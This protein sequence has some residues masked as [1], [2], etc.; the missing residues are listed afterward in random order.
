MAERRRLEVSDLIAAGQL[1]VGDG[2][3]AK[4]EELSNVGIPFARA[5]NI[6][7]GFQFEDADH[8][9][10]DDLHRVGNKVS[11]P[12]D[13][14]FTSKGTVGRFAF[15]QPK[16]QRFVY[17]PQLCFW[18]VI[19][20]SLIDPRFL[21]YWMHSREFFL[22]FK[23]VA[24]QTDMAEYV[25]LTDQRR[26]HITLPD[27]RDQGNIATVLG[28]LD[29]K[30]NLNRQVNATL[31]TMAQA[32]FNDWFVDFGPLRA[33]MG[34]LPLSGPA[35]LVQNLFPATFEGNK[36][37]G[38]SFT[39]LEK[40][41]TKI[42]SGATPRG[43]KGVYVD[44]GTNFIR[45]QNVYDHRFEWDGLAR[46]TDEDAHKLRSV[47]VEPQDILLNITGDSIL[48][49]CVVDP[50]V[51]PARVNQH[52]AI[53]RAAEE[54]PNRFLHFY[55]SRPST[56]AHLIGN[57]AGGSRA[58]VTKGHLENLPVLLPPQPILNAFDT[59]TKPWFS[60]I[61]SNNSEIR[62][63]SALRNLILP[64]LMSGAI[65]LKAAENKPEN[66]L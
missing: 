26:M 23:G 48:R 35:K 39:T 18:R 20:K 19:D 42:G 11:Q 64:K 9:P 55:L 21:F 50:D 25:S 36:P 46:I 41:T 14:V 34:N 63:L 62:D 5:G 29:D 8:F 15:V 49:T 17:S 43:G 16:T 57:D 28:A 61:S 2:Y 1:V 38:W 53:I 33:K 66:V 51:L 52:V 56:K 32:V 44:K 6:N 59:L 7:N 27:I 12:G 58:A 37:H 10:E 4:N 45:S 65:R 3:R 13:V 40:L 31:G 54:I 30:I 47:T 24:G 60:L 22:Q